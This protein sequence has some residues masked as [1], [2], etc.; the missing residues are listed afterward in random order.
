[1]LNLSGIIIMIMDRQFILETDAN[2]RVPNFSLWNFSVIAYS[3]IG[4]NRRI[5]I[6]IQIKPRL[7]LY[8]LSCRQSPLIRFR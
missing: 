1:M 5:R 8:L 6:T 7:G 2:L 4:I 3:M